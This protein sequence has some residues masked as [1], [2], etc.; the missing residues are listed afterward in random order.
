MLKLFK[1][2]LQLSG[3]YKGRIG[4]ASVCSFL[5]SVLSKMPLF[6]A[7]I[8]LAGF[9]ENT[10]NARRC[11]YIGLG[12]LA[13]VVLQAVVHFLSD[14]LQSGAG[15]MMFA[16]QRMALG[17]H[18]RKLPMGYFTAGNIGKI[19]SVLSTDMVFI[20]EVSMS[21]IANMMSYLFSSLI[22]TVFMFV[23]DWR[24]GLV[25]TGIIMLA[26]L[27]AGRMNQ[28]SLGEAA[29]RQEQS[30]HLT[31]AVLSFT[32]G[33][34]VIK[35]YNLIGEKSQELSDNFKKSRD[36]SITFEKKMT[37]WTRGLNILYAFG[38]ASIFGLSISLQQNGVLSLP[39]LLGVL[40]F[41][42]DLF[43]PLKALYGEATRL[44]V[45][46]AALDRIE[47]V[48]KEEELPATGKKHIPA[49][50]PNAPEVCFNHVT[51]A[52]QDKEVLNDIC[53]N[54]KENS[55]LALVGPSG[56]GKSTI[57]N[58]LARL[59]DVKSGSVAIRGTDI[60][61]VPLGELMEQISMVF[62]RVYLFQD[63]IYNNISMG[64]PDATEEDVFKAAKKAR[65]YDFIMNLPEGFQ[66]MVGEGGATL[67]GGEK[68]RISIARCILKDAPI[69]ILDEATASVDTDNESYI[70]EAI[71]EL[72][73]GKTLLVIAHR[74]NTIREAN[75]ILVISDGRISQSGTHNELIEQ[76]GI[77]RD[78]VSI[79][80]KTSGWSLS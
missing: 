26:S 37:P 62:Q 69:V 79:R 75:Q 29:Q 28:L 11:L 80:E 19:S 12:L 54:L 35:S 44:T 58:L 65:C 47:S 73:K 17:G 55:M 61:D 24:L 36:T 21:T 76:A 34:G 41:V 63:T 70:Q 20:E 15:Y 56:G 57:A 39:Y 40:L 13:V 50:S 30:E 42:F 1:R 77:Y 25:A 45:M 49:V 60:R 3:K 53:F 31:D 5:E 64:K 43:G 68:Q 48:L 46:D 27:I 33:I 66:T 9:Y 74:L 14:R 2:I 72:V 51:F 10:L 78:F 71:S 7:F 4:A 38:I 8:V 52:Y 23:L 59:W 18:L 67:S 32:E 16:D 22:L 6:F